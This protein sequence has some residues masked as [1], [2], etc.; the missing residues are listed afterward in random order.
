MHEKTKQY[1]IEAVEKG[2]PVEKIIDKLVKA[3]H[4]KDVVKKLA[5][6][7]LNE[8]IQEI[9]PNHEYVAEQPSVVK[10]TAEILFSV[11]IRLAIGV[12]MFFTLSIA[13]LQMSGHA[14]FTG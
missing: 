2:Y 3:G 13:I 8:R 5:K 4:K 9:E 6:T 11:F 12:L 10:V 7:A 1:I 14:G